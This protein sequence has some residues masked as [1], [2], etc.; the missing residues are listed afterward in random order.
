[1]EKKFCLFLYI[2]FIL[3]SSLN[4]SYSETTLKQELDKRI[5]KNYVVF[6]EDNSIM[7]DSKSEIILDLAESIN[8]ESHHEFFLVIIEEYTDN[9]YSSAENFAKSYCSSIE[10]CVF[11]LC[12][13]SKHKI[14]SYFG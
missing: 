3:I 7:D 11:I 13:N 14:G 12:D 6:I 9:L 4:C 10:K 5:G 2:T 8:T 1:M